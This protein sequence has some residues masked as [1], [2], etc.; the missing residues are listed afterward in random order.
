MEHTVIGRTRRRRMN[1]VLEPVVPS[2]GKSRW[3][4]S[5]ALRL[6]ES[7]ISRT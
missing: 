1:R 2:A 3:R 7:T 6:A 4:M 5:D